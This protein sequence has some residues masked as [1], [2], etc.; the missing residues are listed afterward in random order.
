MNLQMI[1]QQYAA[2]RKTLGERFVVNGDQLKAFCR[3]MGPDIDIA[4]VSPE[5]V[6]TFLIG[7][8]PLTTTWYVR[9][10]A[11]RGF[12]RYAISRGFVTTSPLPLTIP[13]LRP[14]FKPYIYSPAELRRIL[15]STES[16]RRPRSDLDA[17]VM[18]ALIL[19][20]YG[21]ALRTSEALSLRIRDV[22]LSGAVLTIRDS[23]FF[24]SRLVPIGPNTVRVLAEYARRHD[25]PSR[26]PDDPFFVG[27]NAKQIPR[28]KLERAFKQ[29][30]MQAGLYR[31]GGPRCQPRLH[32]LRH[33]SAVHRLTSWYR[34]GKDVQKLLPQ[35]SVY[36]GHTLL[37]ATQAYL[38][39]TPNLLHQASQ[40]FERYA[41]REGS[42]D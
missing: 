21:A 2:F 19:L 25:S 32:D 8:G 26:K 18:R 28:H 39:M 41:I 6:N 7:D 38:S 11:L 30:R 42:N 10:N 9:H 12:Y 17:S 14:T 13:K 5:K 37:A 34:E 24:K 36:M 15:D 16:C 1:C 33:T 23:K 22:D 3:T 4:D 35:L 40:R 31:D 29:I 20:M 27:R